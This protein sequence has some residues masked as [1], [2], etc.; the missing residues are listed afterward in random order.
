M[1]GLID[2]VRAASRSPMVAGPAES[3]M[4]GVFL[5]GGHRPAGTRRAGFEIR[6]GGGESAQVHA[7]VPTRGRLRKPEIA[8]HGRQRST[9]VTR[10]DP[11]G[12][13]GC[14]DQEESR[15]AGV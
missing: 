10:T 13:T 8:L 15:Y 1:S 14:T 4:A 5:P 12:G 6:L 7:T 11:A 2:V 3:V 9:G